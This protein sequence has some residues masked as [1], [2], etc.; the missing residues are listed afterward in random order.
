[1]D[2][3]SALVAQ[4]L[5]GT[6]DFEVD[7]TRVAAVIGH[8]YT[9]RKLIVAPDAPD[10]TGAYCCL[11]AELHKVR[12]SRPLSTVLIASAAPGEGKSLTAANL[13]LALS[14]SY[15]QRVLLVDADLRRPALHKLFDTD[16]VVGLNEYLMGTSA[17]IRPVPL[18]ARL[19]LLPGGNPALDPLAALTSDRMKDLLS[20]PARQ[21]EWVIVDAP[22]LAA[23]PDGHHLAALV[24]GVVLVVRAGWT[25]L[26]AVE[27]AIKIVGRQ[28]ILGVVLNRSSGATDAYYYR[29]GRRS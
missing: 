23:F 27:S 8:R 19:S 17:L 10:A 4:P 2:Q 24:Q 20:M 3:T 28:A 11:A 6:P 16:N 7:A 18:S 1:M 12:Q 25:P 9:Q 22:P 13:G 5:E 21:N 15:R 29:D 14:G 26:A